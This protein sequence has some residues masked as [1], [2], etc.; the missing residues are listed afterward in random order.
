MS[1]RHSCLLLLLAALVA[2]S[3]LLSTASAGASAGDD[4]ASQRQAAA[5][6]RRHRFVG[7]VRRVSMAMGDV[8]GRAD[9]EDPGTVR[10]AG[11]VTITAEA[12]DRERRRAKLGLSSAGAVGSPLRWAS[13]A[14]RLAADTRA[15]VLRLAT[16]ALASVPASADEEAVAPVARI[17][18]A[19]A[20]ADAA[21][22]D[23]ANPLTCTDGLLVGSSDATW[24][25]H[26]DLILNVEEYTPAPDC[27]LLS[28]RVSCICSL[29]YA[30]YTVNGAAL[31]CS[32]RPMDVRPALNQS[33]LC[34]DELSASLGLAATSEGEYCL[35]AARR[36]TLS[37]DVEWGYNLLSD[38]E[39][40]S[41]V[42]A[43]AELVQF[44]EDVNVTEWVVLGAANDRGTMW[45]L[46]H[47]PA[48]FDYLVPPADSAYVLRRDHPALADGAALTAIYSFNQPE[49][50]AGWEQRVPLNTPPRPAWSTSAAIRCGRRTPSRTT[51]AASPTA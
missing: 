38:D 31:V 51:S 6:D 47:D 46:Q 12:A 20:A 40:L 36:G 16:V 49:L 30:L 34:R 42:T 24:R 18:H 5:R 37:F 33:L 29:D 23:P 9:A 45:D 48:L 27:V 39:M 32:R 19:T 50:A 44:G 41:Y 3:A 21:A 13:E 14:R 7:Y 11:G 10:P 28:G 17:V 35:T 2:C 25:C 4:A 1:P 8:L 15:A 22:D 26:H 43:G